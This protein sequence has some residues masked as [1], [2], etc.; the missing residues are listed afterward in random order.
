MARFNFE[1][2]LQE[3]LGV[4][5]S[6]WLGCVQVD[7]NKPEI[8]RGSDATVYT[9]EL[10]G[11]PVA[12][13]VLHSILLQQGNVGRAALLQRFGTECLVMRRLQHERIVRLLGI[14]I[15]PNQSPCIVVELM[16]GSLGDQIGVVP[17][18]PFAQSLQYLVDTAE[19]LR[20]LHG[21]N[22]LHRDLK[23]HNILITAGR[24]KIADVGLARSLH[25]G[26]GADL[27]TLTRCPGTPYYMPPESLQVGTTYDEKLDVFSLGVV[28]LSLLVGRPPSPTE[29]TVLLENGTRRS[30]P[31]G[32]RRKADLDRLGS[33]HP[34]HSLIVSC[35]H[36]DPG[37]RPTSADVHMHLLQISLP[38]MSA[39]RYLSQFADILTQLQTISTQ[40]QAMI[41]RVTAVEK[42]VNGMDALR[43]RISTVVTNLSA[44][45]STLA[46]L[47]SNDVDTRLAAVDS[48]F[49]AVDSRSAAVD[50]RIAALESRASRQSS[51]A[52]TQRLT[53]TT[54]HNRD[55]IPQSSPSPRSA[56]SATPP[57]MSSSAS[58]AQTPVRVP[59]QGSAS[60]QSTSPRNTLSAS[61]S[62]AS[63]SA[64]SVVAT[65]PPQKRDYTQIRKSRYSF[66][67]EGS[68][69]D[70][71][72]CPSGLA[73]NKAGD[74]II[75]D[76]NNHRIKIHGVDGQFKQTI[77][78][79]GT[80]CGEFNFPS[81]VHVT[82]DERVIIADE[83]NHRLQITDKDFSEFSTIGRRGSGIGEF[84]F[85]T[86]V[87]QVNHSALGQCLAV[88]DSWNHR[89]QV[90]PCS[91]E[92]EYAFGTEGS[93]QGQFQ[94]PSG[95]TVYHNRLLIADEDNHRIQV[96]TVDGEYI[97]SFGSQGSAFG[98]LCQPHDVTTDAYG[99]VLVTDDGN[100][101]VMITDKD[102][103]EFSTIGRRGKGIGEF[104]IPFGVVQVNH[105]ALGQCLAVTDAEN[106]RVQV[107]PCSGETGYA[108]GTRGS[109]QGRFQ[110]PI[111][112]TVY[113]NRLFIAD[114]HSHRIQVRTVDGEYITSFGSK[115]SAFGQLQYPQHVTTDTYGN[116]LV[117]DSG[118]GRVMRNA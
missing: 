85:P 112:I 101:R 113:L 26:Q 77:G 56:S 54:S 99:N 107:V 11:L 32:R 6:I 108:F 58:S 110:Y 39:D 9:S 47:N 59:R 55:S 63:S 40:Q 97:T 73:S 92:T 66:G 90:V 45:S 1:T 27:T 14:G 30:V 61:P 67:S 24:A 5:D 13:K 22:I 74:L 88:T 4:P 23:P 98:Q 43:E 44:H 49:A 29:A 17:R 115:G 16:A 72:N 70:Q 48:R 35:L 79:E 2:Q 104:K 114:Q 102:F 21:K 8:G 76:A 94:Y 20:F 52:S 31:E 46:S 93:G 60:D 106:H 89:V 91:G 65:S 36:D 12:V 25:G 7:L 80:N 19:G 42:K 111:G 96:M 50:L 87:V 86:G 69:R 84:D 68:G 28:M 34:L 95:I 53:A 103:S 37:S 38:S 57:M 83:N 3:I 116:V 100:G 64:A 78:R 75:C 81:A 10:E 51:S 105:S 41:T 15:A 82:D 33:D 118:N 71:F 117:V 18:E 62:A 109:G